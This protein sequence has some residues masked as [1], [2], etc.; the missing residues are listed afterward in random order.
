MNCGCLD[1]RAEAKKKEENEEIW[2][3]PMRPDQFD[4]LTDRSNVADPNDMI[5]YPTDLS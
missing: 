3:T 1:K 5:L 2:K 4:L